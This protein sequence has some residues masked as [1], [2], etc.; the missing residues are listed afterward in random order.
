VSVYLDLISEEVLQGQD[1]KAV[2]R[3]A[4]HYGR[5]N[6]DNFHTCI[7]SKAKFDLTL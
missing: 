6:R 5:G 2:S 4:D 1:E 7:C 3:L